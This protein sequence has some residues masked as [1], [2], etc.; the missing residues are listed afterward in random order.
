MTEDIA[1]P[2]TQGFTNLTTG[3][4]AHVD[5]WS[6]GP[7]V[8]AALARVTTLD[9]HPTGVHPSVIATEATVITN[10]IIENGEAATRD[11]R[12]ADAMNFLGL[13]LAGLEA[14]A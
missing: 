1:T 14:R 4:S 5:D 2:T 6:D 3:K 10:L 12:F 9:G 8:M 13:D 11:V 7:S